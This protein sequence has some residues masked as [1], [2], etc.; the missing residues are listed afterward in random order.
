MPQQLQPE[1]L[2]DLHFLQQLQ[3]VARPTKSRDVLRDCCHHH[4]RYCYCSC[5]QHSAWVEISPAV[6]SKLSKRQQQQQ[7][8]GPLDYCRLQALWQRKLL[9]EVVSQQQQQAL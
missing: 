1:A 9:G 2:L 3:M 7:R 6:L 4:W 8:D 5:C